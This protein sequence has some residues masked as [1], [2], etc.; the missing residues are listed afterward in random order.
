MKRKN[1]AN[2]N[3][4]PRK[5]SL[6]DMARYISINDRFTNRLFLMG[7]LLPF[8]QK[9]NSPKKELKFKK[10]QHSKTIQW[11]KSK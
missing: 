5:P 7:I 3:S 6:T 8:R 4:V 9:K 11:D 2:H 10:K 1:A